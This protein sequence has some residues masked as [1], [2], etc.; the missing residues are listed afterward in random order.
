MALPLVTIAKLLGQL[1]VL[2]PAANTLVRSLR[3]EVSKIPD[4]PSAAEH[5]DDI[6]RA[7]KLQVAVTENL[8]SQLQ[9]IQSVLARIQK[10]LK[11]LTY[12]M[13]GV[14]V[15]AILALAIAL[16]K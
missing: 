13:I 6:E 2:L 16:S 9:M 15:L 10:S 12:T 1:T 7:L 3:G 4:N 8:T 11:F 5:L 14:A